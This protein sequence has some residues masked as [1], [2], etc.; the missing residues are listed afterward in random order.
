MKKKLLENDVF[1]LSLFVCVCLV[2]LGG[3]WLTNRNV[4]KLANNE[5]E[6]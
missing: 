6:L 1:Y 2:A 4:D 3:I 5:E